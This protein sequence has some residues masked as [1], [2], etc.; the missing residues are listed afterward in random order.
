MEDI[1]TNY[2]TGSKKISREI[3]R[4]WQKLCALPTRFNNHPSYSPDLAPNLYFLLPNLKKWLSVNRFGSYDV[5]IAETIV[6][7]INWMGSENQENS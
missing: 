2:W 7:F 6:I 5:N 3:D 1:I 4:I